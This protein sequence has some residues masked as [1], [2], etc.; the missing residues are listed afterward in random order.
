[1]MGSAV[2]DPPP[3]TIGLMDSGR[4]FMLRAMSSWAHTAS[5]SASVAAT[6]APDLVAGGDPD[7]D[8]NVDEVKALAALMTY[9]CAIVDV[10]YGGSKGGLIIDPKKH[11]T[12]ELERITRRF[13]VELAERGYI[14]PGINVPAPRGSVV[15]FAPSRP[16][17]CMA[18]W[19]A[20]AS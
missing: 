10:P 6:L 8:V 15:G 16:L 4:S 3:F 12:G 18:C 19:R 1:M 17:W 9:K 11:S 2:S 20:S 14:G 5:G 7:G 13:A